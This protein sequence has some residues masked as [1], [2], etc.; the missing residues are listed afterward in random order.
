[1]NVPHGKV[2]YNC[3]ST[4]SVYWSI[5]RLQFIAIWPG[6]HVA[7]SR[8]PWG[9]WC[10]SDPEEDPKAA[11][12]RGL[13]CCWRYTVF[14]TAPLPSLNEL[15][16]L[17]NQCCSSWAVV[18][19]GLSCGDSN[20]LHNWTCTLG[21]HPERSV[22]VQYS[23]DCHRITIVETGETLGWNPESKSQLNN[24]LYLT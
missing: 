2:V 13:V 23:T 16:G 3:S 8:I 1:M 20:V 18:T 11:R 5:Y 4:P 19:E 24:C 6:S 17:L 7:P 14:V 9:R 12:T 10:Q 22:Q 15:P 21:G